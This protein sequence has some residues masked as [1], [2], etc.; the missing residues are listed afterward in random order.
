MLF[1]DAMLLVDDAV[2]EIVAP[3]WAESLTL[4]CKVSAFYDR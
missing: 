3:G 2:I 1:A 4:Y